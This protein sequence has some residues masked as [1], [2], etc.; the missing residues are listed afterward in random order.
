M[1]NKIKKL[2][3]LVILAGTLTLNPSQ[4]ATI[5]QELLYIPDGS[6]IVESLGS[7]TVS[8]LDVNE[9]GDIDKWLDFTLQG[10]DVI[11]EAQ[12]DIIDPSLF[13][14]FVAIVDIVDPWAGFDILEFDVTESTSE[15]FSY[16]GISDA[17]IGSFLI[18][19]F[20]ISTGDLVGFGTLS[21]GAVSV[22]PEPGV[23]TL[24]FI[25]LLLLSRRLSR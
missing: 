10:S 9:F 16:S 21:L 7:V 22:V 1:L 11:T 24:F 18:D 8:T 3:S 15:I 19:I 6:T 12:A 2:I 25:A 4:A 13:G 20:N 5:T 14:M 17:A 23:I